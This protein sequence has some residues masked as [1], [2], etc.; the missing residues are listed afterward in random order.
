MLKKRCPICEA[1]K[2]E[3]RRGDAEV[4]KQIM[5]RPKWIAY[6][7]TAR[8]RNRK[9]RLF[10]CSPTKMDQDVLVYVKDKRTG[11][12]LEVDNPDDGYDLSFRRTG[13]MLNTRYRGF[14]FDRDP[15]PMVD[16]QRTQEEILETMNERPLPSILNFYWTKNTW[17]KCCRA[18]PARAT[19]NLDGE[20]EYED[21]RAP[22]RH[23]DRA[24]EEAEGREARRS[25]RR[26]EPEEGSEEEVVEEE[27]GGGD[28]EEAA[29]ED[30]VVGE[31]GE[32]GEEEGVEEASDEGEPEV[33]ERAPR[34]AVRR[35]NGGR[36]EEE[37]ERGRGPAARGRG[38]PPR[39]GPRRAHPLPRTRE[40]GGRRRRRP[41]SNRNDRTSN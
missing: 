23:R 6:I 17:K 5:V 40:V 25:T 14:Q 31:E 41:F 13:Q 11:K 28:I 32:G 1:E 20:E 30:E 7:R 19:R 18:P 12:Y 26:D 10:G 33:E 16:D 3:R 37:P 15:T 9:P 34:R 8:A 24:H 4:A 35:R 29:G 38:G 21:N 39:Q 2:D 22:S 27:D 36:A